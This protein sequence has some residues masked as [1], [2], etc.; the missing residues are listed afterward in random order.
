MN[1]R[2]KKI[3][4]WNAVM[5]ITL[6]VGVGL[7]NRNRILEELFLYGLHH[8]DADRRFGAAEKLGATATKPA[9]PRTHA[10]FANCFD[11]AQFDRRASLD[12]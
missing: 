9:S 8:A 2:G 7:L 12:H 11:S 6:V 10:T 5:G 3:A 1:T 4:C